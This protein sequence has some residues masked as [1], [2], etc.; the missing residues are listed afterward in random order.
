MGV[1]ASA[2]YRFMN[3]SRDDLHLRTIG[4]CP[5]VRETRRNVSLTWP[6]TVV[7]DA[8]EGV[9]SKTLQTCFTGSFNLLELVECLFIQKSDILKKCWLLRHYILKSK[10]KVKVCVYSPDIFAYRFSGLSIIYVYPR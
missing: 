1:W 6:L 2:W 4:F 3:I 9:A 10:N 5:Y 7:G 8:G